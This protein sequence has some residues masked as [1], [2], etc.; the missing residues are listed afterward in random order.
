VSLG[1]D[2]AG[3]R[4][5]DT[6]QLPEGSRAAGFSVQTQPVDR[7]YLGTIIAET[8]TGAAR[9]AITVSAVKPVSVACTPHL[10]QSAGKLLCEVQLSARLDR[11]VSLAVTGSRGLLLPAGIETRPGQSTLTFE[12]AAAPSSYSPGNGFVQVA[13]GRQAAIDRLVLPK[14]P[15]PAL[16]VPESIAARYGERIDFTVATSENGLDGTRF[17]VSKLPPGARFDAANARFTW[18]PQRSDQ[19]THNLVFSAAGPDG[20]STSAEVNVT[21]GSGAPV[22]TALVNAASL[23]KDAV[24]SPGSRASLLGQWLRDGEP[25]R[26]F[27][28]GASVPVEASDATRVDF[29]CP[30]STP[31]TP[32]QVWLETAA[33]RTDSLST[34]LRE[35]APGIFTLD[36]S[37]QGLIFLGNS[38]LAA[39]RSYA[40]PGQP[41]QSGD[42]ISIRVTGIH[43]DSPISVTLGDLDATVTS[44][45][46]VADL[47]GA[48]DVRA[49]LPAGVPFGEAVPVRLRIAE[50]GGIWPESNTAT[51]AIE[52]PRP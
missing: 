36:G 44:I 42:E 27:V 22:A 24:C 41:A 49:E 8:A 50:G 9:T 7:D 46:P 3:L 25:P 28:N 17:S 45:Q 13:F 21:V 12:A 1:S 2:A 37:N 16:D 33:G 51:M 19:G 11:P 30:Q 52:P 6:V 14:L 35:S 38:L 43:P 15:G 48:F 20:N 4:V 39:V 40:A 18:I 29:L 47:P 31:G 26:V 34:V 32:L 5:P 10:G 23:A